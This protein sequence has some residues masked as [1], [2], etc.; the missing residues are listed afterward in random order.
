MS[1]KC[2]EEEVEAMQQKPS[3]PLATTQQHAVLLKHHS[4][5]KLDNKL[6]NSNNL[7]N[8]TSS[9][10][11]TNDC[12]RLSEEDKCDYDSH[13]STSTNGSNPVSSRSPCIVNDCDSSFEEPIDPRVQVS[14][15]NTSFNSH[16][17]LVSS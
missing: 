8:S 17:C 10:V 7:Y 5:A 3:S 13:V 14:M 15:K 2:A 6:D 9:M 12:K 16:Q 4:P 11:E 1:T